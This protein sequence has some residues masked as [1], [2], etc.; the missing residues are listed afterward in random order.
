MIGGNN[1]EIIKLKINELKP[2]EGNAKKHPKEQVEQIKKSIMEFGMNDPIAIDE[3]NIVIEGHGR[4]LALRDMNYTEV[5]C[6]RLSHLSEEQ[7]RAYIL[8]HNKLTLNTGYDLDVLKIELGFLKTS[9]MDIALTGFGIA[10]MNE[11]F[12]EPDTKED[13]FDAEPPENPISKLGDIWL[14]GRHRLICGDSTLPETYEKLMDGKKANLVV[15]DPPY[16][17]SYDGGQGTIQNDNLKDEEFLPFLQ[18]AFTNMHDNMDN[19]ASIYIFHA[20]TKGLIFRQAFQDAG[21]YLSGVCQWVKQSLVMGRSPYQWRNEPCIFGWK[22]IGKHKWYVGRKETTVWE[23]DKPSK[24]AL[25]STMKPI[26]L[27]AYPINNSSTVNG[28]VLEPFSG[29]FSTGI[30]CEQIDRICYAIEIEE[31]FVDVGV[32]RYI[33]FKGSADEVF[34]LRD[35]VRTKYADIIKEQ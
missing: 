25:H 13:D 27:I 4:L 34:L 30:A 15:T 1:V 10:E 31:R 22:K 17:V 3:N 12:G 21:F 6:I 16:G 19:E 29:S 2:F 33:D 24:S 9:D 7:K 23:F 20:D 18:K 32:S 5:E 8:A 35:G 28:I 26:A 11:L 14:L